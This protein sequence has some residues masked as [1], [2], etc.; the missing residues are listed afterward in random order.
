[1]TNINFQ[2]LITAL[3]I[4]LFSLISIYAVPYLLFL[5]I[6]MVLG[7]WYEVTCKS[8]LHLLS[9]LLFLPIPLAIIILMIKNDMSNLIMLYFIILWSVDSFALITGRFIGGRKLA[10]KISPNKTWSGFITGI[11]IAGILAVILNYFFAFIYKDLGDNYPVSGGGLF[12]VAVLL[13]SVAQV[14][15]LFLSIFKRKFGVKDFGNILP[16]HGGFLDRF[17]SVVF[18]APLLFIII[19]CLL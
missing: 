18:S 5:V 7:E 10:P 16:G 3:F 8:R 2:K 15:D 11:F 14:S 4:A 6:V 12:F 19:Y 13:A 1:M 17:D 9:G